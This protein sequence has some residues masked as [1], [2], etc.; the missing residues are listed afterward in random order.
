MAKTEIEYDVDG[1]IL[2]PHAAI[3]RRK[4]LAKPPKVKVVKEEPPK[5]AKERPPRPSRTTSSF[6]RHSQMDQKVEDIQETL[7]EIK[8]TLKGNKVAGK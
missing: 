8:E 1:R 4:A 6:R 5:K 2:P 3:R 7:D